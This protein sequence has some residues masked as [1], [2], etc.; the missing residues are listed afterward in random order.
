MESAA[1]TTE[2]TT[3][4]T[5]AGAE[6]MISVMER[7][8]P[9]LKVANLL[10]TGCGEAHEGEFLAK[11]L[12]CNVKGIDIE[13]P[14]VAR[15]RS[16]PGLELIEGSALDLPYQ[17]ETFDA[18]FS[19]HVIEHVGDPNKHLSEAVRVL[20]HGGALYVGTPNRHRV[21]GYIGS[22]S[23]TRAQKIKW[24]L[25]DYRD[26]LRGR[27]RNELGAHAGFSQ[28]ELDGLM[29]KHVDGDTHNITADYFRFKYGKRVP[30][31]VLVP[32]LAWPI[33]DIAV[34]AVYSVGFRR[35]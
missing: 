25:Q 20:R 35:G 31:V 28:R 26:R 18:I 32:L 16:R 11:R 4:E 30:A 8:R 9:N 24:N 5:H 7:L 19:H 17:N 14:E 2:Y 22:F 1:H 34:P 13:L 6:H 15:A 3:K 12:A 29:K 27:F 23:A 10:V 21:V 33:I